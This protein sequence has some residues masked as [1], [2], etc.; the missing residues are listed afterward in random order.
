[1]EIIVWMIRTPAYCLSDGSRCLINN[2]QFLKSSLVHSICW[3]R[4]CSENCIPW[5]L[6]DM[7][8][9]CGCRP[10]GER[11]LPGPCGFMFV[12]VCLLCLLIFCVYLCLQP[13][14]TMCCDF[15]TVYLCCN[16]Y[17]FKAE[18][19]REQSVF[20]ELFCFTSCFKAH[21]CAH[22]FF[23][24]LWVLNSLRQTFASLNN[25]Q[26]KKITF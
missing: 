14:L 23:S 18:C 19:Y 21:V 9:K 16:V 13:C 4:C 2:K 1:M 25:K 17:A 22:L 10:A 6:S 3:S 24:P 11:H 5:Y 20:I 15:A 8:L 12:C 26:Q 7:S